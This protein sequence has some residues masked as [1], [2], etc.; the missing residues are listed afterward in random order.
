[1]RNIELK[2][3]IS[4]AAAARRTAEAVAT[5]YVGIE[6]QIDTYFHCR[7][8]RLKLREIEGASAQL[9]S[10][11]R[12]NADGPKPSDYQIVTVDDAC[13]LKRLLEASLGIR[14]VVDKRREIFLCGNIRIH[15]DD[16][17]G[18][19]MFLEFEAVLRPPYDDRAGRDDVERLM[20]QFGIAAS[21]LVSGSYSDL[22]GERNA[23]RD[24]APG[25]ACALS[26]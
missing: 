10:Y 26:E 21:D 12:P 24:V 14:V 4:D 20:K 17:A 23:A 8:G 18:L 19:G 2:A 3:R 6:R 22:I 15:L 16:V 1:M 7:D 11:S 9:I 25:T 13:R 5:E